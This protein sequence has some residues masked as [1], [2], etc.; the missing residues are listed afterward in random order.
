MLSFPML[1]TNMEGGRKAKMFKA[2]IKSIQTS[3]TGS[4]EIFLTLRTT[5]CSRKNKMKNYWNIPVLLIYYYS[6]I[7]LP[8]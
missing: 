1:A 4:V 6:T 2:E 8:D 5:I 3:T 7:I